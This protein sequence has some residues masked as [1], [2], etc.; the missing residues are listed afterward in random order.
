MK[1]TR[2]AHLWIGLICSIFILMESITGLIMNEP[3]LIGQSQTEERGEFQ[4]GQMGFRQQQGTTDSS[5]PSAGT[6]GQSESNNQGNANS[7][8]NGTTQ[9]NP[10]GQTQGT[11]G[12]NGNGQILGFRGQAGGPGMEG[13]SQGSFMSVIRDLHEGK[14]GSTNVKW[15]IDLIAI[16][17][18]F[19]TGTGIYLSLKVIA[20]NKKRKKANMEREIA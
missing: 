14:I 18:I 3:W 1:K 7:Q 20:A 16:A 8:T 6:Q 2:K 5:Q 15:L 13:S 4:P 9:T 19:L 12:D 11:M 10:N 17:M